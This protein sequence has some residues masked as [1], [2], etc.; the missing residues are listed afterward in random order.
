MRPGSYCIWS[1]GHCQART[2]R[3]SS[4]TYTHI[5][6]YAYYTICIHINMIIIRM[7]YSI[8][9]EILNLSVK[10]FLKDTNSCIISWTPHRGAH[11]L[12]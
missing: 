8:C 11:G 9:V 6:V 5:H 2:P 10:V 4:S 7:M 1:G 12:Y 3:E